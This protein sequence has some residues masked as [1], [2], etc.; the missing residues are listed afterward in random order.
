[1]PVRGVI[2]A[3]RSP[4]GP[5]SQASHVRFGPGFVK[6][7]EACRIDSGLQLPPFLSGLLHVGPVLLTRS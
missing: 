6:E 5:A 4:F 3:A 1:M 2:D 7:Y